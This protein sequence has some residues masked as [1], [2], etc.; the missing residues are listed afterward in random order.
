MTFREADDQTSL[1]RPGYSKAPMVQFDAYLERLNRTIPQI[2]F[3][4]LDIEGYGVR[5]LR[6][7]EKT[8]LKYRPVLSLSIYHSPEELFETKKVL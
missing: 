8:I 3:V 4:K 6:G 2:G 5:A 7:M 1:L